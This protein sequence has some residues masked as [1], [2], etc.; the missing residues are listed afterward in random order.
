MECPQ[1]GLSNPAT[2][3]RC[4]K[5]NTPLEL[6][7]LTV[8]SGVAESWSV[9][10]RD[11]SGQG[12]S[13]SSLAL[14]P[15]SVLG[16]RYDILHLLG[17]GG[18]GAVYKA[19]DRELDRFVA[20]K[21][22]HPELANRPEVLQRFKQELILARQVTHK[23]VIRI[24]DLGEADKVKFISM[25]YVDGQDLKTLLKQKGKLAPEEVISII[26]Q[27][28]RAL[29]A[30]HAEGVIHRDLKPQN[31]MVDNDR[32]VTVM[33][34]G[35]AR[36]M[37]TP[38]LTQTGA[39]LGTPEYMSPE[40]AKGEE[41]RAQSDLFAL[42]IISYELL[43]GKTPYRADTAL[44]TMLKRTQERARPPVDLDPAIPRYLS[45]VVVRCLEID[46]Q[47][48]YQSATGILQDLGVR[49]RPRSSP[50]MTVS[51][52][53][54]A[55]VLVPAR[56]AI[57]AGAMV[58]L[59]L[60]LFE[61][62]QKILFKS[63]PKQKPVT[64]LVADFSNT[65]SEPLFDGALEPTFS[66]A[67]EGASFITA[68]DRGQAHKIAAQLHPGAS[69]L[70]EALARL[71]AEREGVNVVVAGAI[72][73]QGDHYSLSTKAVDAVTGRAI[74]I[75]ENAAPDKDAVLRAVD[76]LA[77]RVRTALGDVTPESVQLT[78]AETFTSGS[79]QAAH[80]YAI[81]QNLQWAGNFDDAIQHY[82][83]AVQLDS[84]LGRAYAGIAA[85]YAN[86]G[87]LQ[88]SE[89]YYKLA[90]SKID[91]MSEREK[92]RTRVGYYLFS[93]NADKAVEEST[94]LVARYPYDTAGIANLAFAY[95]L[96]RDLA[97]AVEE[98]RRAVE[99]YPK[100]VIRR[101][102]LALYAMYAGDFETAIREHQAVLGM[103]ASFVKAYIG[104]ALSQMAEGRLAEATETYHGLERLGP[105]GAAVAA[106]G[107]SDLALYEGRVTD[108]IGILEKGIASDFQN[109]Y[110]EGA[111]RKLATLAETNLLAGR[112][113]QA[114]ANANK[115]LQ[116][117]KD[118]NVRVL[119]A[120][121][122]VEAGQIQKALALANEL[123]VSIEPDSQAYARLIRGEVEL[124]R[125]RARDA[126]PLFQ[127]S[128]KFADTWM[129][130]FDLARAYIALG[131]FAEAHSELET[132]L[133][134][135]GEATALFLDEVPTYH[136]FP[137]VYYYLGR[138][139]EGLKSPAAAES[140]K[141]FLAI[142]AKHSKDPLV[143]DARRRVGSH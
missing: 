65:T 4:T 128:K 83:K 62:R 141:T 15:G 61:I 78:E 14:Q 64:V 18:M 13:G 84:N 123:S 132:C 51:I 138:T 133:K 115:A 125:G 67:L 135:R 91:R 38:G 16:G 1:C 29:N 45:D 113:A 76:T 21:V 98:G 46:P 105:K 92:Y 74:A 73:R 48:R 63:Q 94:E 40:Q 103:N 127:E 35:I 8:T 55:K 56:W 50:S 69:A 23:N 136:F 58:L 39:V 87:R 102:N 97:R 5:C 42:G 126:L 96:R 11:E 109:K 36:S 34:F 32:K 33:D 54:R 88:E 30:A 90:L 72:A 49:Q 99:I 95:F 108:A 3:N 104:L 6:K 7:G 28:C 19:K 118:D 75:S 112:R 59:A 81:A 100:N 10:T 71:V 25:D 79:L 101:N 20:L 142:K 114:I 140:Y 43:T 121:V 80:E 139:Q 85:L 110:A 93:R 106:I 116:T 12:V 77:A 68:Y 60:A 31:I 131:A 124:K 57:A 111:A 119:A 24:Y 41:A 70:D 26:S 44:A 107:L 117:I 89:K 143:A 120:R 52:A 9:G 82:S 122:Y 137:P 130:R 129:G 2:A 66:I 86:T 22:I 37:E 47:L 27:V 53:R 134:R 17:E